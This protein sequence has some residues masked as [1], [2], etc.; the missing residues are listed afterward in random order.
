MTCEMDNDIKG[1]VEY[2]PPVDDT[3]SNETQTDDSSTTPT[4]NDEEKGL[5]GF[6]FNLAIISMLGATIALNRKFK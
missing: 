6:A 3:T 2:V 4:I 5:P 1:F